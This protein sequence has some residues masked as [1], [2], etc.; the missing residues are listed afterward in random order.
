MRF[1]WNRKNVILAIGAG[2]A[3]V[4]LALIC[5]LLIIRGTK[6]KIIEAGNFSSTGDYISEYNE[7]MFE[8]TE[9]LP[10]EE[11]VDLVITSP[12]SL[13]LTVTTS[14]TIITGTSDVDFP[15][16]INETEIERGID[17]SFSV[18]VELKTGQNVFK[19][20]HKGETV[21][22][23]INY[24]YVVISSY[25]P[26]GNEK[27]PS[28]STFTVSATARVGSNITAVF[29]GVTINLTQKSDIEN[30]EFVDYIGSFS[31]PNNNE[32]DI[33]LGKVKFVGTHNG[34]TESFYSGSITCQ[35]N[36]QLAGRS[37]VAEIVAFTA[38]TFTGNTTDDYS[39]PMN[40]YLPKGTVDYCDSGLIYDS[41][42]GNQYIKLRCGRRVYVDTKVENSD[43]RTTVTTRYKGTLPD[44]NEISVDSLNQ[45]GRHTVITLNTMWKAPFLLDIKPQNYNNPSTQDFVIS[46]VTFEYVEIKF[47]YA[48]VF[49]GSI[50]I[51]KSNQVFSSAK[52]TKS[53]NSHILR[54]YLKNKGKFYGWDAYY[55]SKGQ[56][57]FEFLNPANTKSAN[58]A[59]GVDLTGVKVLVDAGHGGYDCGAVRGTTYESNLNLALAKKVKSELESI[60]ATVIMTRTGNYT[61]TKDE[62]R[63]LMK[64]QRPDYAVSIH[65]NALNSPS[66]NGYEGYYFNAFSYDPSKMVFNRTMKTGLYSKSKFQWHYFF[67]GRITSCPLVLTENGYMSNNTDYNNII[68]NS[69]N[70]T[71]AKAIV[72]GIAD[73]FISIQYTPIEEEEAKP[74]ESQSESVTPST[75]SS[76][77]KNNSSKL[78]SATSSVTSFVTSSEVSSVT[79]S[80]IPETVSE[81]TTETSSEEIS[82]DLT[83]E[84]ESAPFDSE[85]EISSEEEYVSSNIILEV[86]SSELTSYNISESTIN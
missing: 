42:S 3:A 26:S 45:E 75:S 14:K 30:K 66:S 17:G 51:P 82:S 24:K 25:S 72:K 71:K 29:N 19:F 22:C 20:E 52:I 68:S 1:S 48:T 2:I 80:V 9:S 83:S 43:D 86:E 84:L 50:N 21:V 13:N 8:N 64:N 57:C 69:K 74:T 12:S 47:C 23:N 67:L 4:V 15:L 53:G 81:T 85:I 70:V 40:N 33:N 46:D 11:E 34:I 6:E 56:L 36:E 76:E 27:Y 55:N 77:I 32:N 39:N 44:H 41:S 31:L 60:G 63:Q 37:Y 10:I 61:V 35:K 18:E 79:S 65:H 58:N 5:V 16:L 28:G 62:R 59:Y 73:Y 78:N 38:E 7:S 49:N 54:L